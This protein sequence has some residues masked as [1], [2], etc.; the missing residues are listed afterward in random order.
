MFFI[1]TRRHV[2]M[3]AGFAL[4][5]V[6]FS[7]VLWHGMAA[8]AFQQQSSVILRPDVV[9]IDPGHGGEDG[10]AVAADGTVESGINLSIALK[11]EELMFLMGQETEMTRREDVS[12]YS[13][14]AETLRQKKVSD[15]QNRVELVNSR[16]EGAILLSIHQNSLPQAK[17]VRGAQVF[18]N[19]FAKA[20]TLAASIQ[21]ALN[22]SANSGGAKSQKSIDSS[23]YL[24][25]HIRCPGIL[26]EC[27]FLS[28]SEETAL[29]QTEEYQRKLALSVTA[30]YLAGTAEISKEGIT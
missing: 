29:L 1:V 22:Q 5:A 19:N 21:E 26:V 14:G 30:G 25:A 18:Y 12:I 3:L 2:A 24:M 27:G 28:N 8:P 9:I 23:V 11:V 10:G 20:E 4:F 16:G 17:S 7:S 15:L 13:P 6:L